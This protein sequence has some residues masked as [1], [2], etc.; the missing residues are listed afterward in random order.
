MSR[1]RPII[2]PVEVAVES[3]RKFESLNSNFAVLFR[4]AY[5]A[6]F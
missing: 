2:E 1:N 6:M 4:H 5:G 3:G